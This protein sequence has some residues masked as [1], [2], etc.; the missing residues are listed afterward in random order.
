MLENSGC[1][2]K[3]SPKKPNIL[4]AISDDQSWIHTGIN[5]CK[6]V[7]T[8]AFDRVAREGVLFNNAFCAAPQCSP[9]RAS[10]LTGRHIWQNREAGT[11]AS[12]F[13]I[14]L[15][16]FP[17]LL[18]NAGY[19]VGYTGKPWGPGNWEITGWERNPAGNEFNRFKVESR[20]A[21]YI[22]KRDYAANFIDFVDKKPKDQP[23][24][25]WFGCHEPHRPYERGSGL[26]AG[27]NLEDAAVP[28]FY[29]DV[30]EIRSD[31]LDYAVEIDW[32]DEH[33]GKM[34]DEL[35][36]IGELD[37]TIIVVTSDNGMPFPRAKA[38]NYEYGIHMPLAVR[39]GDRMEAGR[40]VDDL[41]S[42]VDFAPTFLEA[43]GIKIPE[44]MT[45]RSFLDILV[46]DTQGIVDT[47]RTHILTGR[48]RHT[49]A[50]PD[51]LAYPIRAIRTHDYLYIWNVKPDRYPAGNPSGSGE[52]EGFHDIDPC[53]TKTY[54]L[55][56]RNDKTVKKYF[57]LAVAKR[58]EEELYDIKN[59]PECIHNL[60][61]APEF[62]SIAKKL[63]AELEKELTEQG[64]PRMLGYGDIIESYPRYSHM[65][66]FKGFKK[67]GEY[68]PEY[69]IEIF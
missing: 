57:E 53:P 37:N 7:N 21:E 26:K 36:K 6:F 10:I 13:P 28:E 47:T 39:W 18:E 51:N 48:E 29:P 44:E 67:Q 65:R 42:F 63:R 15:Q 16:V 59:D 30:P 58:P 25:F 17:D 33:L 60:A 20:P 1:N 31:I 32:F 38:N 2:S 46:S 64:D 22:S 4:F 8:P 34:L 3:S 56:N 68:N 45:G 54:L 62:K 14:D 24:C 27:K 19:F 43:A 41:I 11:H 49:H 40:V 12:N 9:N 69:Q 35:E 52:P 66:D 61:A 5:G 50:R 23:F 55:E